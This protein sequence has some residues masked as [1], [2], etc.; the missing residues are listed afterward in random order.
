FDRTK[1]T[2]DRGSRT[3][4]MPGNYCTGAY[5]DGDDSG[6]YAQRFAASSVANESSGPLTPTLALDA[7][8][9][10]PARD[11]ATLRYALPTTATV[12]LT[13]TDVLGRTV[14]T[15][16]EGVQPAGAHE[17]RL[18]LDDLPSGVYVVRLDADGANATQR[19]TLVR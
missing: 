8:F 4:E 13:V 10:N 6:V 5:Q 7:V 18:A 12:R 2:Q 9:P 11:A 17:A 3:G 15:R 16:A 14:L 19:V 1:A